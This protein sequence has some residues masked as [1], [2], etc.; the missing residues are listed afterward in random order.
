M[1]PILPREHFVPDGEARVMPDGRLYLYGSYD[2]SGAKEYGSQM[3]HVFSTDDMVHWTDHGV[4]FR[5]SDIPWL[6]AICKLY[7]PD[8]I[9][10][11]GKYYL[12]F[13]MESGEEG[14]AVAET[15][16]GPFKD[17]QPLGSANGDGIDPSIFIDDDGQAYYFW[18]QFSLKGAK[19]NPDMRTLDE[20]SIRTGIIDEKRHGFHEGACVRR[21]GD[22]YYLVYTDINRGRATCMGYSVSRSPLGPYE[23]KGIIIDNTGCDPETW[24]N[25]GSIGEYQGQWYVF[26]HRSSQNGR[27][28][29]RMCVEPIEFAEDG[30][31]KEVLPTTQGCEAPLDISLPIDAA[32]ACRLGG[33]EVRSYL[34]P[35]PEHPGDEILTHAHG[36]GWAMYRYVNF[37]RPMQSVELLLRSNGYGVVEVWADH[38]KIARVEVEPTKESWQR[39]RGPVRTITGVHTLY[40]EWKMEADVS[41]DFKKIY[42][43]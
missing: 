1:N 23:Y 8:C 39:F 29:R 27:W 37:D 36:N 2:I 38:E 42:F 33:W 35:D 43:S 26:Y 13:C 7:A 17:P 16:W 9:H 5:S 15:P 28:S 6:K 22:L 30:S 34:M 4:A 3:L 31:I 12:Y 25:H 19:M 32:R 10:R 11:D 21:R 41:A 20:S 14:V 18:G 24:N 40:L